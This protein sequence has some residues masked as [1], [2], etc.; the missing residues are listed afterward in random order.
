MSRIVSQSF[1]ILAA[2]LITAI[3]IGAIVTPPAASALAAAPL[4]A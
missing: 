2:A 4:L 3:S 1:A